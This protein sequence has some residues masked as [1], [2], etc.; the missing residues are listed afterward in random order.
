MHRVMKDN[1]ARAD[2][3]AGDDASQRDTGR[4]VFLLGAAVAVEKNSNFGVQAAPLIESCV[5][6][7]ALAHWGR[8]S[9]SL[10][11]ASDDKFQVGDR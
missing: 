9:E 8:A 5:M 11:N 10:R 4:A 7:N 1:R 6:K 2:T 3:A